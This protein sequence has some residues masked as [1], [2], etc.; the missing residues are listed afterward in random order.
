MTDPVGD[1]CGSPTWRSLAMSSGTMD[2]G[3][4]ACSVMCRLPLLGEQ[5]RT[6]P[7]PETTTC[8]ESRYA[9]Y[10]HS[11]WLLRR[12]GFGHGTVPIRP[13]LPISTFW[14]GA[15]IGFAGSKA[16]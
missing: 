9:S 3:A 5:G 14:N 2:T 1:T 15:L 16:C 12:L 8:R 6:S 4:V 7:A 11:R 10:E 13:G